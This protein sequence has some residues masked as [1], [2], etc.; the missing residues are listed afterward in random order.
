RVTQSRVAGR[1][2]ALHHRYPRGEEREWTQHR[3]RT[4]AA[5]HYRDHGR[6][7]VLSRFRAGASRDRRPDLSGTPH[8][9]PP[10]VLPQSPW[11]GKHFS[12][13]RGD[14]VAGLYS[15]AS[16]HLPVWAAV[17]VRAVISHPE[18]QT[19]NVLV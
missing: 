6:L 3:R 16:H 11:S 19:D 12:H 13:H 15:A 14:G 9:V 18:P 1:N 17:E 10:G 5:N 7:H 8:A 2:L 4:R